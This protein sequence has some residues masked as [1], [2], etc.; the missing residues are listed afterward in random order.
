MPVRLVMF[1]FDL[2]WL[3]GVDLRRLPLIERR[4]KLRE[5]LPQDQRFPME[6]ADPAGD[7][8]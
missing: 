1:A 7:G 4:E 3:E 6:R 2:L 5:L 8:L